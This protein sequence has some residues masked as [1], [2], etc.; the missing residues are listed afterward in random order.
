M[1]IKIHFKSAW[2]WK[3]ALKVVYVA[4]VCRLIPLATSEK[5]V[6]VILNRAF[7]WRIGRKWQRVTGFQVT[8]ERQ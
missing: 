7:K 6:N 1:E 8:A 2:W 4:S 5:L 3:P